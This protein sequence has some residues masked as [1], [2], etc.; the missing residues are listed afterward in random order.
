MP[1]APPQIHDPGARLRRT[2]G[3]YDLAEP[4]NDNY[5]KA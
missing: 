1:E 4:R 3:I 2:F 5:A